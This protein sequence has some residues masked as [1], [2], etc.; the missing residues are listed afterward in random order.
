MSRLGLTAC[1][2]LPLCAAACGQ[3]PTPSSIGQQ[4]TNAVGSPAAPTVTPTPPV[5][6][7]E[8]PI[9]G[10]IERVEFERGRDTIVICGETPLG[11]F[12]RY[13]VAAREGQQMNVEIRSAEEGAKAHIYTTNNSTSEDVFMTPDRGTISWSGRLPQTSDYYIE[14]GD[15][16]GYVTPYTLTITIR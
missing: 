4:R 6:A 10:R 8:R 1:L 5:R 7:A 11:S 16:E 3:A 2:L 15:D 9:T 14:I 12:D 13:T